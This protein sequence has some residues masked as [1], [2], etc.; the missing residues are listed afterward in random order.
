MKVIVAGSRNITKYAIVEKA[1]QDSG[2]DVTEIVSGGARGVD[3]MGETWAV[4]R[5][6]KIQRFPAEWEKYGVSAGPIRNSK[7]AEYGEALIAIWDGVSKGTKNMIQCAKNNKLKIAVFIFKEG[8]INAL[9]S[10]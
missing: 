1:I 10:Y 3:T 7:M 2:F 9:T 8:E 4:K 6:I 5:G